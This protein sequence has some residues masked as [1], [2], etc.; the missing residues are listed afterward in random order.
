MIPVELIRQKDYPAIVDWGLSLTENERIIALKELQNFDYISLRLGEYVDDAIPL[1]KIV[2]TR[3]YADQKMFPVSWPVKHTLLHVVSRS[4]YHAI[5]DALITYFNHCP[6]DYL[7]SVFEDCL[8]VPHTYPDIRLIWRWFQQGWITFNEAAFANALF[9]VEMYT[10]NVQD[11]IIWLRE[12][13]QIIEKIILPFTQYDVPVLLLSHF[14]QADNT[15]HCGVVTEFW[16]EV[17]KQLFAE[18][19]LPRQLIKELLASL[20][21]N[22]KKGRIDWHIR[23][24]KM[25]NPQE[26]EWIDNQQLLFSGLNASNNSVVNFVI[27]TIQTFYSHPEFDH[28]SFMQCFPVISGREKCDKSLLIAL[29]IAGDLAERYPQ[30]RT[31]LAQN[32]SGTLIQRSEKLQ[33][34]TA[35]LMLKYQLAQDVA[36]LAEPWLAG[37]KH[38]VLALLQC[39][40]PLGESHVI[41]MLQHEQVIVPEN[42][43]A[44]L[45]Q[46]GKMLENKEAL[47]IELFYAGIIAL[48][49]ELPDGYKKQ[50]QPYYKKLHKKYLGSSILYSLKDFFQQW[51]SDEYASTP[52]RHE[53]RLPHLQNQNQLVLARLRDNCHLSLLA[54]PSH[55]PFYVSPQILVE[56]L[57][58]HERE[59]YPVDVDDLI[60]ACNRIL[61][62]EVTEEVKQQALMLTGKYARAVH[63]MLGITDDISATNDEYL[64]LWTQITRTRDTNG[65]FPQYESIAIAQASWPGIAQPFT[66]TYRILIDKNEYKTWYR[67]ALNNRVI[68]CWKRDSLHHYPGHYYYMSLRRDECCHWK[69]ELYYLSLV[70]HNPDSWLNHF[71]PATAS[72]NEVDG[73]EECLYP[74]QYLLENQLRVHQAGWIYIAVC[75]L[76]E[77]KISRD[78]AAEYIQ[79]AIQHNFVNSHYLSE[80]IAYLL[81]NKYAPVNRFIEYLDNHNSDPAV[82]K[83]QKQIVE[84]CITLAGDNDL[85]INYKK[86]IAYMNEFTTQG[87]VK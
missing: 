18:N 57:L 76:F 52:E 20:T 80:C 26:D 81:M 37:L 87:C 7:D 71:I 28:S 45:F 84:N 54:T 69:D 86:I 24:I 17:F 38:S 3:S 8:R 16:D 32:V 62:G 15:H 21:N 31:T 49:D 1:T 42:W 48:Q 60:V 58:A 79:L 25:F 4:R 27:Q 44:L 64:P 9:H 82:R 78:L 33:L 68:H 67:L 34:R 72:G 23:L 36:A 13:P 47:D 29:D 74:L 73:F 61:P 83:F 39:D 30:Y 14:H 19:L 85:P 75:L 59:N 12:N 22:F 43:D 11:E 40:S 55:T 63:Y 10:R 65:V 56:R 70:P 2:C 51:L 6:P 35:E 41:P 46:T 53:R 5:H 66:C 50:L 77:K